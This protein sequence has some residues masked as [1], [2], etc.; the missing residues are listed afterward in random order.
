MLRSASPSKV[1]ALHK[2]IELISDPDA[3]I[4]R[5]LGNNFI[6]FVTLQAYRESLPGFLSQIGTKLRDWVVGQAGACCYSQAA[7]SSNDSKTRY[8][9]Q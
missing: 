2:W 3:D 6:R 8:I 9:E 5:E 7:L 1:A 4:A